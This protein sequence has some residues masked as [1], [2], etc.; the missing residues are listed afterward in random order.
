MFGKLQLNQAGAVN[1]SAQ[2]LTVILTLPENVAKCEWRPSISA[3][4]CKYG[5]LFSATPPHTQTAPVQVGGD[6]LES[7]VTDIPQT[8]QQQSE[9]LFFFCCGGRGR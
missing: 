7:F 8:D 5:I 3:S 1:D 9:A 2:F 4:E 6:R